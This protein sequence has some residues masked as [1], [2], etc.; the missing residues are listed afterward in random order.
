MLSWKLLEVWTCKALE[1]ASSS[2]FIWE[3]YL[4]VSKG[5][6]NQE[7]VSLFGPFIVTGEAVRP[8]ILPLILEVVITSYDNRRPTKEVAFK[9][10]I[11][12]IDW[13]FYIRR[14]SIGHLKA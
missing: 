3:R 4:L 13:S 2:G 14:F 11:H 1:D 9:L 8:N 12:R 6:Q 7:V 5:I 10:Q